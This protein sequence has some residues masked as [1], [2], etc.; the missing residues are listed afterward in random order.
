MSKKFWENTGR[1]LN[2]TLAANA[3]FL[4]ENR[5]KEAEE[6]GLLEYRK[7][8]I[9]NPLSASAMLW[10]ADILLVL[11]IGLFLRETNPFAWKEKALLALGIWDLVEG[12]L[13]IAYAQIDEFLAKE[14]NKNE[15]IHAYFL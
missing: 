7:G 12:C 3:D 13:F 10:L 5:Q 6:N 4:L 14:F 1:V 2:S 11:V 9:H 8:K 15:Q